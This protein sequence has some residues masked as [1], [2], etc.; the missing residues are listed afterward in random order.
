MPRANPHPPPTPRKSKKETIN[1]YNMHSLLDHVK[2][3]SIHPDP[4]DQHTY[5]LD[6][7]Y[8]HVYFLYAAWSCI[9]RIL[10]NDKCYYY[11]LLRLTY[12][13][14]HMH[15]HMLICTTCLQDINGA[16]ALV[17]YAQNN[18]VYVAGRSA[19]FNYSTS[20]KLDRQG[21]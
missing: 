19:N 13:N 2:H 8:I 15:T 4:S 18:P 17:D 12:N 16:M 14:T 1:S 11:P 21:G 5:T 3:P 6:F 7:V 10:L 20:Q 9:A